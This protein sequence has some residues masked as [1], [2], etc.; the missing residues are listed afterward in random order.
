MWNSY[1]IYLYMWNSERFSRPKTLVG[2]KLVRLF[3][4]LDRDVE[5]ERG[6]ILL[7]TKGNIP[8]YFHI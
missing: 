2:P 4:I 1:E 7:K 3:Q 6:K 8:E 5:S